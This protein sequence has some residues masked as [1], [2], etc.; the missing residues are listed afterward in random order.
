MN[1]FEEAIRDVEDVD[2]E[3]VRDII[4]ILDWSH[5]WYRADL[6]RVACVAETE[7]P[8][9]AHRQSNGTR[10]GLFAVPYTV[11]GRTITAELRLR[12]DPD[13]Y[14]VA[15]LD[16]AIRLEKRRR[17]LQGKCGASVDAITTIQ[18]YGCVWQG[19]SLS[20]LCRD[21][22]SFMP[23]LHAHDA[24]KGEIA[25]R[26]LTSCWLLPRTAVRT[27]IR[28]MRYGSLRVAAGS[29]PYRK[30]PVTD[31][32]RDGYG[33]R[34]YGYPPAVNT[35]T[36]HSPKRGAWH[37]RNMRLPVDANATVRDKWIEVSA[38][39]FRHEGKKTA[40]LPLALSAPEGNELEHRNALSRDI[41]SRLPDCAV[42]EE[43]VWR[44]LS[45]RPQSSEGE[46]AR[47]DSATEDAVGAKWEQTKC[48]QVGRRS[49]RLAKKEAS[50]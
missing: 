28:L 13:P 15:H 47:R 49:V 41:S 18:L 14:R 22:P 26:S 33:C 21:G 43:Q 46:H 45:M 20:M 8:G 10:L 37:L 11:Y 3:R 6:Y 16:G 2:V 12:K 32:L 29:S 38:E 23:Y 30:N 50:H 24:A 31:V 17:E 42:K 48:E 39:Q 19:S 7:R 27:R 40:Q 4:N 9:S 1:I 36:A 5:A 44:E 34:I 35:V 25:G